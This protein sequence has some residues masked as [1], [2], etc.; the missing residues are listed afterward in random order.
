[1]TDRDDAPAAQPNP[2]ALPDGLEPYRRTA[3]FTEVTVP[4]GLLKDHTTKQGTWGVIHVSAGQLRYRI[5]DPRRE[6]SETL[7]SGNA[8][9]G[10]VEPTILH[11]VEPVGPVQFCVE[12]HRAGERDASAVSGVPVSGPL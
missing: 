4:A 12:F 7:L 6:P 10:I 9:P 2:A 3:L 8:A 1:M 5:T 11:H